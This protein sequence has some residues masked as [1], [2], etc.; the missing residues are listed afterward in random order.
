M[1]LSDRHD[2]AMNSQEFPKNNASARRKARLTTFQLAGLSESE[3]IE[4]IETLRL[5]G[6]IVSYAPLGRSRWRE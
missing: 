4:A 5:A 3:I 2:A 1:G 6:K